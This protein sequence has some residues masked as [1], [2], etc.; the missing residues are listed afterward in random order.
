MRPESFK[1]MDLLFFI[2]FIFYYRDIYALTVLSIR[3]F[4]NYRIMYTIKKF[5]DSEEDHWK[6]GFD[7]TFLLNTPL[8]LL[9]T[10][11]YISYISIIEPP[12]R[13]VYAALLLL[14][15]I[16]D[17]V[18]LVRI[19]PRGI[20]KIETYRTATIHYRNRL[21]NIYMNPMNS[22]DYLRRRR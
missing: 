2:L 21:V 20:R 3:S 6:P 16:T 13:Y 9:M 19:T 4:F 14:I 15:L 12:W 5:L 17:T 7:L 18:I 8:T 22:L 11:V 10:A 1:S